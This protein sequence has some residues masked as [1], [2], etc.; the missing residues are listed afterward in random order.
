MRLQNQKVEAL[1]PVMVALSQLAEKLADTYAVAASE[2]YAASLMIYRNAKDA[3]GSEGLEEAIADMARRFS[4]K[5]NTAKSPGE[6][7]AKTKK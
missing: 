3:R 1:Y 2:A 7:K 4:R 6:R 5:A